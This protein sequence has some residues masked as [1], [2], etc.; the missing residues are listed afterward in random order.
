M[1]SVENLTKTF[2]LTTRSNVHRTQ[3]LDS[4]QQDGVFNAL[5][6]V[7]F[8][9][10]RGEVLGL[11]GPNGAGKTTTL[12]I[13]SSALKPDSGQVRINDIDVIKSP[14][15]AKQKIG[16]LSG[17]TGLYGR[18]TARENIEFF[19]RLHGVSDDYLG[20]EAL[21][22]YE[23][24]AIS[25]FLDRRVEHLSTGMQQK[26]SIARAV[27]HKPDVLVLDEP[28]TGLDIMATETILEFIQ[29]MKEQG[30]A[31]IFSTHHL[32][33]VGMLADRVTVI[34]NG[35]SAFS[36]SMEAFRQLSPD[37]NLRRSF[38]HV[39]SQ[40]VTHVASV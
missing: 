27:I 36:D 31:V 37:R 14:M 18:L 23:N 20:N 25:E 7:S 26:V 16:F 21:Q 11:L 29:L 34:N 12:R 9:C 38:M 10:Q 15:A 40:E 30:T 8:H 17:K 32:D 2:S 5:T 6:G 33:E 35:V 28:T 4:R 22:I 24:L 13:L 1:I 19:A 39:L 3:K